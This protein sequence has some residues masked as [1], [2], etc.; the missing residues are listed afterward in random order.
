MHRDA[1]LEKSNRKIVL[2]P[3]CLFFRLPTFWAIE[4]LEL[5]AIGLVVNNIV[6]RVDGLRV[7]VLS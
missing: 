1:H 7:A 4:S 6:W 2:D 5:E 3:V